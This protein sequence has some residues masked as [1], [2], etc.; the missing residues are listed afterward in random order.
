VTADYSQE[1]VDFFISY[2]H[3]D[4]DWAE[5][6]AW[7]LEEEGYKTVLQAWDFPPGSN[8]VA[9]MHEAAKLSERTIAILSP[10]YLGSEYVEAEWSAAFAK[11][12]VGRGRTLIPVRIASTAADGLLS[13]I[14]WID[15]VGLGPPAAKAALLA[16]L[17]PGRAKPVTEPTFPGKVAPDDDLSDPRSTPESDADGLVWQPLTEQPTISWR[18]D[19]V[20]RYIQPTTTL[21]ELHMIPVPPLHLEVRR[22]R[23]LGDELAAMGRNVG[24]FG[25]AQALTIEANDQYACV[26][27]QQERQQDEAGLAVTRTTQRS[28]WLTLPHDSMGSV[29]DQ[30]DLR[31]RLAT[32][33]KVLRSIP[34]PDSD[35]ITFALRVEPLSL[36]SI[37]S[38]SA[39]GYR[40]QT[41]MPFVSRNYCS[42]APEDTVTPRALDA[43]VD[44]IADE[45]TE[46]LATALRPH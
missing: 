12:P 17:R 34:L 30:G 4:Q 44:D 37:G 18:S 9:K 33:I 32:L 31:P 24:V 2:N 35:Q 42:V 43:S 45:L 8:F 3:A 41:T 15:L 7:V 26:R 16:G 13:Q 10:N 11:D 6:V 23:R 25:A 27:S 21:V 36:L 20:G 46:R 22:L 39:V 1:Q 38:A 40:S 28:A 14:V 29:F 19:F 5:W